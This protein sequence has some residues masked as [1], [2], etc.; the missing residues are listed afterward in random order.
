MPEGN[1]FLLVSSFYDSGELVGFERS[2]ADKAA[3]NVNLFE[4]LLSV[5]IVH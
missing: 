3:V 2:A 5:C 4:K 1:A